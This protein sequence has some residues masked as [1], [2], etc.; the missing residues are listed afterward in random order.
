MVVFRLIGLLLSFMLTASALAAE[1]K[2][3]TESP[4]EPMQ[5]KGQWETRAIRDKGGEFRYCLIQSAYDT[6]HTLIVARTPANELNIGVGI[7]GAK[8]PAGE[9]WSVKVGIDDTKPSD[10]V[11]VAAQPDLLVVPYGDD[12]D[13]HD[14]LAG[15]KLLTVRSATDRIAFALKGSRKAMG[16]LKSCVAQ[17]G[18]GYEAKVEAPESPYPETLTAIL[19]AAGFRQVQPVDLSKMPE[20]ERPAD[21]A[22]RV[23]SML[24]GVRERSVPAEAKLTELAAGHVAE[25]TAR[26]AA[27]ASSS[28]GEPETLKGM[29]LL[30]ASL[31]C[32][33]KERAI[34]V[35][36]V[37]YLTEN[38][39]FTVFFHEVPAAD[40]AV[41][42]N[43]RDSIARVLRNVATAPPPSAKAPE[44]A[45]KQP[46]TTPEA[47]KPKAP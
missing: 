24:G 31:D 42:A 28:L 29:S 26:C 14:Q 20:K 25:L 19:A 1:T 34:H 16:D 38:H 22:W 11:A 6:G 9:K 4:K 7:P 44:T 36:M 21:Y 40:K 39:L 33:Q 41:A 27:T 13:L 43:A 45:D 35:S 10:K 37:F 47:T 32:S 23:G 15:G 5:P 8:M 30:T 17:K 12:Q 18:K 46:T 3:S 2:P